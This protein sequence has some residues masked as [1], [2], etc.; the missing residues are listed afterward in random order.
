MILCYE[1]YFI[2]VHIESIWCLLPLGNDSVFIFRFGFDSFFCIC[3]IAFRIALAHGRRKTYTQ[4]ALC[5]NISHSV[6]PL[7][8]FLF[9]LYFGCLF[10]RALF[11]ISL[12]FSI[13]IFFRL[14]FSKL[15]NL[16]LVQFWICVSH[17]QWNWFFLFVSLLICTIASTLCYD[18][19]MLP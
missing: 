12:R 10:F 4:I 18:I 9:S 1:C 8:F 16:L 14:L 13:S 3:T 2:H 6:F 15:C 19:D 17:S 5:V 7:N 11:I